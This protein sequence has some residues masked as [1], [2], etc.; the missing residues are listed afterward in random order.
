MKKFLIVLLS[1][2]LFFSCSGSG[3]GY[4]YEVGKTYRSNM[5]VFC[6][7]SKQDLTDYLIEANRGEVQGREKARELLLS[8]RSIDIYKGDLLY[9]IDRE[10]I[11]GNYCYKVRDEGGNIFWMTNGGDNLT[12]VDR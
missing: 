1:S 3:S 8:G 12:L 5:K 2:L 7:F 9:I 6:G 11:Q 10:L 4:S